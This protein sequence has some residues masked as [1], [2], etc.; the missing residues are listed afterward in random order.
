MSLGPYELILHLPLFCRMGFNLLITAPHHH[1]MLNTSK[2][3]IQE[4]VNNEEGLKAG[5]FPGFKDAEQAL[6]KTF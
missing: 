2:T 6:A 1:S 5:P 3:V 4:A